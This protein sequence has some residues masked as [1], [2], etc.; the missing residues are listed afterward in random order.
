MPRALKKIKNPQDEIILFNRNFDDIS[1]D[2]ADRSGTFSTLASGGP[3]TTTSG[4]TKSITVEVNDIRNTYTFNKMPIIPRITVF[5]D[6]NSSDY[7]WPDGSSLSAA[8]RNTITVTVINARTVLGSGADN[9]TK[10]EF[11]IALQNF[12]ASDH[13][14]YVTADAFYVP[15][16]ETGVANRA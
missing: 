7:R 10:A 14:F 2:L 13:D 11:L 15:A 4:T 16:P 12:D 3:F 8:Q 5:V 6:T 1:L 9:T